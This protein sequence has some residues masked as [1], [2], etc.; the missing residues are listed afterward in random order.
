MERKF[1]KYIVQE[2]IA[3]GGMGV[4]YKARH[5][6]LGK[7]VALK[8][9]LHAHEASKDEV[10][11]FFAEA[12]SVARLRHPHIVPVHDVGVSQ[13]LLYFTMDFI[14]GTTL[15]D[16]IERRTLS[17][18]SL[19]G[20]LA[21]C[22][23][24]LHYA[25]G[26]GIIHRDVKPQNILLGRDN[27]P[28]L[29]DFGL[30]KDVEGDRGSSAS[31]PIIGTLEY[32]SPEQ[33]AGGTRVD[34]RADV[35]GIGAVLYKGLTG[36]PVFSGKTV[37]KV[38]QKIQSQ[39]P[40]PPSRL[41]SGVPR[42]LETICL[43]CLEKD[44]GRRYGSAEEVA[45]DLE[46][47][48]RGDPILARPIG[49]VETAVRKLRRHRWTAAGVL[50]ALLAVG[51]VYLYVTATKR[52]EVRAERQRL[53]ELSRRLEI[54]ES[55][56]LDDMIRELER[57]SKE[58]GN[59]SDRE[60][61]ETLLATLRN[62]KR[63]TEEASGPTPSSALAEARSFW[64]NHPQ[65]FDRTRALLMRVVDA[66]PDSEAA[67][68]ARVILETVSKEREAHAASL[69][70][71]A[72]RQ[73]RDRIE[74]K[75]FGKAMDLWL[76]ALPRFRATPS[77]PR[78]REEVR[79]IANLALQTWEETEDAAVA[80][81]GDGRFERA[82]ALLEK[83]RGFGFEAIRRKAD[84]LAARIEE[85]RDRAAEDA[86]SARTG[87]TEAETAALKREEARRLE[88]ALAR[89][90][91]RVRALDPG[92]A[93]AILTRAAR[94]SLSGEVAKTALARAGNFSA[95]VVLVDSAL[96]TFQSAAEENE[97]VH[98]LLGK[99]GG[100]P[101]RRD[102]VIEGVEEDR[103]RVQAMGVSTSVM[104]REIH[105]LGWVEAGL[106]KS[107]RDDPDRLLGA[108][109]MLLAFG[110]VEE[111][112]GLLAEAAGRGAD[113]TWVEERLE[114]SR[115]TG[116]EGRARKALE[117][118]QKTFAACRWKALQ[119]ALGEF[120]ADFGDSETARRAATELKRMED[121]AAVFS[122]DVSGLFSARLRPLA[123]GRHEFAYAFRDRK[124]FADWGFGPSAYAGA[125][126]G[127]EAG[128]GR[129]RLR[130]AAL[131]HRSRLAGPVDL[132]LE[133]RLASPS[134]RFALQLPGYYVCYEGGTD[135]TLVLRTSPQEGRVGE[136]AGKPLAAGAWV[137]LRLSWSA[138][139][140]EVSLGR[141]IRLSA[142]APSGESG[143]LALHASRGSCDFR[144]VVFGAAL[145]PAWAK[146]AKRHAG[147]RAAGEA[148]CKAVPWSSWL[149]SN[150]GSGW[151]RRPEDRW[152]RER[153]G[154]SVVHP[155]PGHRSH[156]TSE[157]VLA[158]GKI[159]A[160]VKFEGPGRFLAEVRQGE[161]RALFSIPPSPSPRRFTVTASGP[162]LFGAL[163]GFPVMAKR[164]AETR[165]AGRLR[166]HL[167]GEGRASVFQVR[168]KALPFPELPTS[169]WISLFDGRSLAG[170][171]IPPS[172]IHCWTATGK[173]LRGKAGEE[174]V[175]ARSE[176]SFADFKLVLKVKALRGAGPRVTVR[177]NWEG[178]LLHCPAPDG[179]WHSVEITA[180]GEDVKATLDG[181]PA[182]LVNTDDDG[183]VNDEGNILLGVKDGEAAFKEIAV[184]NLR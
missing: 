44:P 156:L 37:L 155:S 48:L 36:R 58:A 145:D 121:A 70:R 18:R 133:V 45:E 14:E 75:R 148:R 53:K 179:R 180:R 21:L 4:V 38:L 136:T 95:V 74:E 120:R 131:Y 90:F 25:H 132:R 6:S 28:Y 2:E 32:M 91:E 166:F 105:P 98:L 52:A 168:V 159:D 125:P 20:I 104:F 134:A 17:P 110:L 13:G 129:A 55:M 35:W 87:Q 5:K 111:A 130:A 169:R 170:W 171:H 83:G 8:A 61:A 82:L 176:T 128:A 77:E 144:S 140:L 56:D 126:G 158:D 164:I 97:K 94:L 106:G 162:F 60:R 174:R 11:R 163:D 1:G 124:D 88:E 165:L 19:A 117:A 182:S 181:R 178:L 184:L 72:R 127:W 113:T 23:R 96:E 114:T 57:L 15:F 172:E 108:G 84:R 150:R 154:W 29:T 63:R 7:T 42:D 46:R 86:A 79:R 73:A 93:E 100:D 47:F 65:R 183:D 138:G 64:E 34:F 49:V 9:L 26:Q 10:D 167:M 146:K 3:R 69:F 157:A 80:L 99:A 107:G 142:A 62:R 143:R 24:A 31:G 135:R 122:L 119:K 30:A 22:A 116:R 123:D 50:A 137:P 177:R 173:E 102:V 81:A 92:E 54:L 16:L 51:G 139:L 66:F 149:P 115:R 109:L 71:D 89:A 33:A 147:A 78:A 112:S 59:A 101:A 161:G 41:R 118:L 67:T 76:T 43:K 160:M 153:G 85:M 27:E 152:T 141:D 39:D 103:L 40:R 151:R 68:R 175:R 12:K